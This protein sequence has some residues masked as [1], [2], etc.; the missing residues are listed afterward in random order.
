MTSLEQKDSAVA[1]TVDC[2]GTLSN[3]FRL[4]V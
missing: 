3:R 2:T 4:Q 1:V